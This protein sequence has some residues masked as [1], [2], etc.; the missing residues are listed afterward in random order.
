LTSAP[1][2]TSAM[3]RPLP[4][5]P[6][7][8]RCPKDNIVDLMVYQIPRHPGRIHFAVRRNV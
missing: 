8:N 7:E 2:G 4:S 5:R 3:G 1:H 6:G